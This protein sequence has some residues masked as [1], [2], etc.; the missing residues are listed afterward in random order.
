ML[1]LEPIRR[2]QELHLI[3]CQIPHRLVAMEVVIDKRQIQIFSKYKKTVAVVVE[4]G[5]DAVNDDAHGEDHEQTDHKHT[6]L[7]QRFLEVGQLVRLTAAY[8]LETA[9][10][11]QLNV[12]SLH[13][14]RV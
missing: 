14:V 11:G 12:V 6:T 8:T 10:G 13:E 1:S 2:I 4:M 3:Q 7:Q 9:V 5:Q